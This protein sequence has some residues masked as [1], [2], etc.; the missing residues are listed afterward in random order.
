[1]W[2]KCSIY[3]LFYELMDL[4]LQ[5]HRCL[6]AAKNVSPFAVEFVIVNRAKMN[7]YDKLS[8]IEYILFSVQNLPKNTT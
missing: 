2:S 3:M 8:W 7:I 6:W 1:M 5:N 4:K